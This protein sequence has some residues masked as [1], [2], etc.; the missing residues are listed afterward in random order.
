M[1]ETRS[2]IRNLEMQVGQLAN[3]LN[4]RPQG[5]LPSN[6][7]V[8][9]KEQ[10]QAITL[11]SGKE[12]EGPSLKGTQEK[13][14]VE[15]ESDEKVEPQVEEKV[16]E[17]LA[18]KEKFQLVVVDSNVKIPYPQ[19]LRKNFLDKQFSKFLEVFKK[20]HINIPFAEALEQMPSYV[21]F[22]KDILSKKRRLEDFETM[23]LTEECSAILQ[24]KL[25][26]KLQD[27]GS[28]TIPC[29]I[30]KFECKHALCDLGASINLMPLSVFWKLGL[31]EAKPTTITLQLAD[32]S[33][34]HP[35]G[36]IEDV[37]VKVEKFIF[38]A[39]F[40]VLDMEEDTT[41]P[42]ILGRPFSTTGQALIDVQKGELRLRVQGEE[43]VF[44]VFK[45]MSYPRASDSCFN[46]DVIDE[47]VSKKR[48]TN[49]PL[50]LALALG[51]DNEE[52]D[53]ETHEYVKW[54]NSYG[55]YYKKIFEEL[56]QVPE[57]PIPSIEK[58][59]VLELKSLPE[60]L[61]YV[62]LGEKETLP[63]I[64]SSLLSKGEV[65]KLLRVL[66]A[67]KRAIG[68]TLADIRGISPSTVMHKILMEEDSK[69]S[70]VAQRRLNSSTK[71]VV[72]KQI[73]NWLDAGVVY[74][75]S[76]SAWVSPIQVVPK[77]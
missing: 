55:P 29:T 66:R 8:N 65:E 6:T 42:I 23:A 52:E 62:Y 63:V 16:T 7:V 60:H 26:Q 17:G 39:D 57:R 2:S 76:Y 58:P 32:R 27:P 75:I 53:L 12:I 25:P 3:M 24:R 69:P 31:G 4:T 35:R 20:L 34:K 36:V 30:G 9:P 70:I 56:G 45:A 67:H 64:I 37:L 1:T 19:R 5:N 33:I 44:N 38:P 77:K 11:R 13:K 51:V 21:K 50:E 15:E 59:P 71:D 68:W 74:P 49:D 22:M 47:V 54:I 73:L 61:C 10:C 28:F 46:V 43:V 40:I 72:R 14:V 48:I 41:V 18:T